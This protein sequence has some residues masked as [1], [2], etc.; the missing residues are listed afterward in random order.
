[1]RTHPYQ[2]TGRENDGTAL[3]YYRAR[4]YSPTFQRFIA[5]YPIGF[6]GGDSDLY[7]YVRENPAL[8]I[9]PFGLYCLSNAAINAIA[10]AVG[11][12]VAGGVSASEAGPAAIVGALL[13]GVVGGV[14]GYFSSDT[15]GN[16]AGLGAVSGAATGLSGPEGGVLCGVDGGI[17]GGIVTYGAQQAGLPDW[18]SVTVGS[19][20]AAGA[21]GLHLTR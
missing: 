4:Y 21:V 9:D 16:E 13:G 5:Q 10:G 6:V 20:G 11:G 3:Y 14:T 12:A 1:M 19:T 2:F 15:L 17:I 7:A 18:A 8:G